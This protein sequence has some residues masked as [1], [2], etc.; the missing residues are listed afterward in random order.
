MNGSDEDYQIG[1]GSPPKHRQFQKGQS[2]NPYGRPR[3]T[4]NRKTILTKIMAEP[5][6]YREGDR[7][8]TV[9]KLELL[10]RSIRNGAASG[11]ATAMNLYDKLMGHIE[12]DDK[13][14]PRGLLIKRRKLT[15][16]EWADKYGYAPGSE[17]SEEI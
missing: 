15:E 9:T 6:T 10:L 14:Y 1:Y 11:D 4:R 17:P 5:V 13:H 8:G 7:N 16:Q 3:G 2:G 12:Y